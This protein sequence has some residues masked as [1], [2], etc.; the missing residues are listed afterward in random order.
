MKEIA[1]VMAVLAAA[2][3]LSTC[4]TRSYIF[5][6]LAT[7]PT[8]SLL[9]DTF[10]RRLN[11]ASSAEGVDKIYHAQIADMNLQ[12]LMHRGCCRFADT[13]PSLISD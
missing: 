11:E 1:Q 3:V 13:C 7:Q 8:C 10:K 5:P 2:F 12:A 4:D 9:W 6:E